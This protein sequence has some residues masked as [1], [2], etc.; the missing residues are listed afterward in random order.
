MSKINIDELFKGT[1]EGYYEEPNK[2]EAVIKAME[3]RIELLDFCLD[4]D[5]A[6]RTYSRIESTLTFI[7]AL[8]TINANEYNDL[9]HKA[10]SK[11]RV[12]I[13]KNPD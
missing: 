9:M 3:R 11:L 1:T 7:Y 10:I 13:N 2:H 6:K 12:R 5:I 4:A 8:K